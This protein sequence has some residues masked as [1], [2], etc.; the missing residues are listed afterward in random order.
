MAYQFDYS[1][2]DD[3]A[4]FDALTGLAREVALRHLGDSPAK[5]DIDW[6]VARVLRGA[7][8]RWEEMWGLVPEA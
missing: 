8:E 6:E 3:R 5:D 2:E 4:D 1:D 7:A